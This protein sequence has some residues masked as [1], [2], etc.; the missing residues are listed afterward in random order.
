MQNFSPQR[1]G[2]VL[3]KDLRSLVRVR[4]MLLGIAVG[5]VV[6]WVADLQTDGGLDISQRCFNV[7]LLTGI[8]S[9]IIC[10]LLY[11]KANHPQAGIG[12]AMLPASAFEKYL[13]MFVTVVL[14]LPLAAAA[15]ATLIDSLLSLL[16]IGGVSQFLWQDSS[17]TPL[18]LAVDVL[19]LLLCCTFWLA[20]TLCFQR[21]RS[22]KQIA[23][24]VL[25][26]A[27]VALVAIYLDIN[28]LL[29]IGIL[30]LCIV[31]LSWLGVR[32]LKRMRY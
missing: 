28:P 4:R 27:V 5:I 14:V 6:A 17:I 19:L 31:L 2:K 21:Q 3:R 25:C 16:H 23:L 10:E 22:V 20:T 15:A 8:S 29:Q 32:C 1:F 30:L 18:G 9:M 24:F 7:C 13:S 12:F 11:G 26:T